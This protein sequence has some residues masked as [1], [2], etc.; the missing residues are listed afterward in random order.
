MEISDMN[1][2]SSKISFVGVKEYERRKKRGERKKEIHDIL[3]RD[4]RGMIFQR[5][6]K[7]RNRK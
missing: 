5:K 6:Q 2:V 4:A 1:N 7:N 3:S